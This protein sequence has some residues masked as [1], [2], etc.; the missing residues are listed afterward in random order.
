M[1]EIDSKHLQK[2]EI[3]EYT[4]RPSMLSC[5][6]SY[7]WVSLMAIISIMVIVIG[8][9]S[10]NNFE[11][12]KSGVLGFLIFVLLAL[13]SIIV[14]LKRLSTRYAI[15]S[16]GLIKRTGII[17]NNIK[18]VPYTHITSTEIKETI[19]GKIFKYAELLIETSGSGHRMEFRWP[20]IDMAHTVKP[21]V[22]KHIGG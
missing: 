13:P 11:E 8:M 1:W 17:T 5:I 16:R 12:A 18:T 4:T 14:I 15:S 20:F 21:M 3:I 19:L 9:I 6:F 10:S 7:I 22:D 2:D